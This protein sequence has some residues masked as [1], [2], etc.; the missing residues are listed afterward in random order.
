MTS[1]PCLTCGTPTQ[2]TRCP[3]HARVAER[4]RHNPAY[5]TPA[6]RKARARFRR[7]WMQDHGPLCMGWGQ[8]PP[9]LTLEP[10]EVDHVVPLAAG[11]APLDESNWQMRCKRHNV[12]KGAA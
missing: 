2:G 11:A 7:R 1:R 6:Y 4:E 3:D 5:D 8:D 9:H 12:A 10:L